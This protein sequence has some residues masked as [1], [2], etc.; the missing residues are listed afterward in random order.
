MIRG[1]SNALVREDKKW[2]KN[3]AFRQNLLTIV[4]LFAGLWL[5]HTF[6]LLS[7]VLDSRKNKLLR[8]PLSLFMAV[9]NSYDVV[10]SS[11][12]CK[13]CLWL[14]KE[15]VFSMNQFTP[16]SKPYNTT[17]Q[18]L[19]GCRLEDYVGQIILNCP[20]DPGVTEESACGSMVDVLIQRL[21]ASCCY[22]G[23]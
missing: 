2:G 15:M 7:R 12:P 3:C 9:P 5:V 11:R 14:I 18:I 1:T 23:S 17:A 4:G 8:D 20:H 19:G 22:A 13:P 6:S 10:S 16:D 21:G